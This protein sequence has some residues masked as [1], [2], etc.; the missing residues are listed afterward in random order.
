MNSGSEGRCSRRGS[1]IWHPLIG[2]L[3]RNRRTSTNS[4]IAANTTPA[5]LRGNLILFRRSS[6]RADEQIT[7][8]ISR[9]KENII[10]GNRWQK[11]SAKPLS[12]GE[13]G[14]VLGLV[15]GSFEG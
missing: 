7:V 4:K 8:I 13:V 6:V 9:N 12:K 5:R 15:G 11:D 1:R 3:L 14:A 2:T 10:A